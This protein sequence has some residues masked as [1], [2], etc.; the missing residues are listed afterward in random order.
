MVQL[1]IGWA[2]DIGNC[3]GQACEDLGCVEQGIC[4]ILVKGQGLSVRLERGVQD[5][6]QRGGQLRGQ[7]GVLGDLVL[8][9]RPDY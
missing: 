6:W 7:L 5:V 8:D 4:I 3:L 2:F 1:I 9:P